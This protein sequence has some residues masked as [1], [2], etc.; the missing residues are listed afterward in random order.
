MLNLSGIMRGQNL[1]TE[2]V[3]SVVEEEGRKILLEKAVLYD[4]DGAEVVIRQTKT[5]ILNDIAKQEEISTKALAKKV[6]LENL[7]A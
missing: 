7:I 3:T 5:D 6:E 1:P 2:T 4:K